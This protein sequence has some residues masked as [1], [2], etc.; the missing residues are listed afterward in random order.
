[1]NGKLTKF[2]STEAKEPLEKQ[3][4]HP[5]LQVSS[6][7]GIIPNRT[8]LPICDNM[9]TGAQFL[10]CQKI[11]DFQKV[12][13][14]I[15]T[16]NPRLNYP[17]TRSVGQQVIARVINNKLRIID[18]LLED[19]PLSQREYVQQDRYC[20]LSKNPTNEEKN[21]MENKLLIQGETLLTV[22]DDSG[23]KYAK[24]IRS[25]TSI[26]EEDYTIDD[27]KVIV[28]II[29]LNPDLDYKTRKFTIIEKGQHYLA[30]LSSREKTFT[31]KDGTGDFTK[32]EFCV[33]LIRRI[34]A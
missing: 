34:I 23:A 8:I 29:T 26:T 13:G 25:H 9:V 19:L 11:L 21:R 24:Y 28:E 1:M 12:L 2:F 32:P 30:K 33:E 5:Y 17:P 4:I 16:L 15:I 20:L 3:N 14:V 27:K 18:S 6:T 7:Q 22:I 31:R 10:K